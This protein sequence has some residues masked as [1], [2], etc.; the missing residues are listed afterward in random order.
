METTEKITIDRET[1]GSVVKTEV[2]MVF[3]MF[4][5][6]FVEVGDQSGIAVFTWI[7]TINQAT[8]CPKRCTI[9]PWEGPGKWTD[10]TPKREAKSAS[11]KGK[12]GK[13]GLSPIRRT[14]VLGQQARRRTFQLTEL[15]HQVLQ[16][17]HFFVRRRRCVCLPTFYLISNFGP[18]LS[19][20]FD[21]FWIGSTF[22]PNTYPT[23]WFSGNSPGLTS[24]NTDNGD[25][26]RWN[27]FGPTRTPG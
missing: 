4:H 7:R 25:A 13:T 22:Q 21:L 23:L 16:V 1:W 27:C 15:L 9:R 8:L 3:I 12:R 26:N 2:G 18:K 6:E 19:K 17:T 20:S 24:I 11:C 14:P 10:V 5:H